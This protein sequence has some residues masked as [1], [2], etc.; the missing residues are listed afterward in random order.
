MLFLLP[1][2]FFASGLTWS[3]SAWAPG[4]HQEPFPVPGRDSTGFFCSRPGSCCTAAV[5][6]GRYR[7]SPSPDRLRPRSCTEWTRRPG[8]PSR[9]QNA[10]WSFACLCQRFT[11]SSCRQCR[12][13]RKRSRKPAQY[14]P[15]HRYCWIWQLVSVSSSRQ[16]VVNRTVC[17][18]RQDISGPCPVCLVDQLYSTNRGAIWAEAIKSSISSSCG[19]RRNVEPAARRR[20]SRSGSPAELRNNP[21]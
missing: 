6:R 16:A 18:V 12:K 10:D 2:P 1:W 17:T 4:T 9:A 11:I 19:A 21:S 3:T 20:G 14:C 7:C 15:N 13:G 8:N 5:P